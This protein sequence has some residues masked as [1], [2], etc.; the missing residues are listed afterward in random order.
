MTMASEP[1]QLLADGL[2]SIRSA[3]R[4]SETIDRLAM[5]VAEIGM[6]V[7]A[8]I[9]HA[10]GAAEVGLALHPTEL[11]VFGNARGGTPLMQA[12]Q[13]VGI[14]LPLKALAWEDA[15]GT[16]WLTCNDP[17]WIARRHGIGPEVQQPVAHMADILADLTA[18]AANGKT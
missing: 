10:H 17:S 1:T 13:T 18:R 14:D 9:D 12:R 15:D 7:F 11:L 16:V 4:V 3:H 5:V 6:T 2:V 8:R